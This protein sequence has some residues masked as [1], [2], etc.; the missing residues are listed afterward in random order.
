MFL[1]RLWFCRA[2]VEG[3]EVCDGMGLW[4]PALHSPRTAEGR[5]G[6]GIF[7]K[8]QKARMLGEPKTWSRKTRGI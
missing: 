5:E 6:P 4:V 1:T 2:V 8:T 7:T 3:W